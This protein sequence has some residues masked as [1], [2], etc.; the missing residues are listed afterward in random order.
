MHVSSVMTL[1]ALV[2]LIGLSGFLSA[3]ESSFF[4]L[5]ELEEERLREA[6]K[7]AST[8]VAQLRA[9]PRRLLVTILT[10]NTAS[11]VAA[12]VVATLSFVRLGMLLGISRDLAATMGGAVATVAILVFAELTKLLATRNPLAVARSLS[13]FVYALFYLLYPV[14]LLLTA[15]A[16][17]AAALLRTRP[18][19]LAPSQEESAGRGGR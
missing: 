9:R 12:A 3:A 7:G 10:A 11:N 19:G 16:D 13:A 2:V 8:R 6:E 14:T 18:E 4:A 5:S 1:G 15:V 17:G